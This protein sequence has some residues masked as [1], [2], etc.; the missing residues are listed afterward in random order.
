[1]MFTPQWRNT[2]GALQ[3]GVY[4]AQVIDAD[5]AISRAGAEMIKLRLA[6]LPL[7]HYEPDI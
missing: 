7:G 3:T 4:T 2:A 5:S 6:L 1:M